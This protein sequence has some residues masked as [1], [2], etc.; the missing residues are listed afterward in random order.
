M[1]MKKYFYLVMLLALLWPAAALAEYGDP[2]GIELYP[3][4][5]KLKTVLLCGQ[6]YTSADFDIIKSG[7]MRV[8]EDG[9]SIEYDNLYIDCEVPEEDYYGATLFKFKEQMFTINLIGDNRLLTNGPATMVFEGKQITL[10]GGGSLTTSAIWYDFLIESGD[11]TLDNVTMNCQGPWAV[12]HWL[13]SSTPS[14]ITVRNSRFE[15]NGINYFSNLTMEGCQMKV[16]SGGYFDAKETERSQIKNFYGDW[17]GH[18]V[19]TKPD[20]NSDLELVKNGSLEGSDYSSFLYRKNADIVQD[21]TANDIVVEGGNHCLKIVSQAHAENIWDSQLF[22]RIPEN[23]SLHSGTTV[24]VSMLVKASSPTTIKRSYYDPTIGWDDAY[25]EDMF[26]DISVSTEWKSFT[27]Y[28]TGPYVTYY[29]ESFLGK[30]NAVILDLNCDQEHPVEFY[31]DDISISLV[32]PSEINASNITFEKQLLIKNKTYTHENFDEIESGSF[33]VSEDGGELTFENLNIK[34]DN[35]MFSTDKPL[36]LLLKGDNLLTTSKHVIMDVRNSQK[37]TITGDGSL[38][39]QS[40]AL[41]GSYDFMMEACEVVAD[42][43]TLDC[44]SWCTFMDD[45]NQTGKVIINHSKLKGRSLLHV[46]SLTLLNSAFVSPEDAVFDP[47]D[48]WVP[49]IYTPDGEPVY[50]YEIGPVEG[51]FSNR[52]SPWGIDDIIIPLGETRQ[53]TVSMKNEGSEDIQEITYVLSADG[54]ETQKKTIPLDEPYTKTG[55]NFMVTIP[56]DAG[57]QLGSEELTLTVTKVNGQD[58]T[59]DRKTVKSILTTISE[60]VARRVVVEEFTGTWCGWC[61]RGMVALDMLNQEYGDSVITIAVHN[62]DPME[63]GSYTLSAGS[64]PSAMLNRGDIIDP[65]YGSSDRAFGIK[66]DVDRELSIT[67]RASIS[68]WAA[69][70]DETQTVIK[71]NTKTTFLMS[72]DAS[73]YGIGYALLEDGI[74]GTGRSWAQYNNYSGSSSDD[75]NLDALAALP[76]TITDIEYNH[77]AV[78]AWEINNGTDNSFKTIQAGVPQE[79]TYLCDISANTLIQDKSR[80]SVVVLLIDKTTGFIV[81]AAKTAIGDYDPSAIRDITTGLGRPSA[82]YNINGYRVGST[83]DKRVNR[84]PKGIYLIDG[85]KIVVK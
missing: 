65:Y 16:P 17:V 79:N 71:A 21:V 46:A 10:T 6:T 76:Y 47:N 57:R 72:A 9:T 75:E 51:D 7:C 49:Q 64:F 43:T 13:T 56:I 68:A 70:A 82:I 15:G 32:S 29:T 58:N 2:S 34:S 61:T 11:L 44:K 31:F 4:D 42:H 67:P 3:W 39:T 30:E 26:G 48:N 83:S 20:D 77:V 52:V 37:L 8:S 62:G 36:K 50:E 33:F 59:S 19:I 81:N 22:I 73:Q 38:T 35:F 18:F 12:R 63:A 60:P 40:T 28:Y 78:D 69:W 54:V 55:D 25:C 27:G 41:S 80:L 85:R 84:L 5:K 66:E 1:N 23:I 45:G 74:K 14:S 53:A 24:C